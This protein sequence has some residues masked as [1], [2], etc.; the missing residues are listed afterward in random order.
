MIA[1]GNVEITRGQTRLLADRVELNRDTGQAVTQGK[2][3]LTAHPEFDPRRLVA[4]VWLVVDPR[5]VTR[6]LGELPH[7]VRL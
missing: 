6:A 5:S 4:E 7:V 2:V 1:V 3:V